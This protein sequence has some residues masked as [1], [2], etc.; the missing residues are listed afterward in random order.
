MAVSRMI[1]SSEP[2]EKFIEIKKC[3]YRSLDR[4]LKQS[5]LK[6]LLKMGSIV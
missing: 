2:W 5:P 1:D 6:S 4:P 3:I